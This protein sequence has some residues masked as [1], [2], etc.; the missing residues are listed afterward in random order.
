MSRRQKARQRPPIR[1]FDARDT[2]T[3]PLPGRFP[4]RRLWLLL[5]AVVLLAMAA[6]LS[7]VRPW[8][9]ARRLPAGGDTPRDTG[10]ALPSPSAPSAAATATAMPLSRGAGVAGVPVAR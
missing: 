9:A 7:V 3:H 1:T 4:A 2:A 6:L 10:A 5:G 8:G